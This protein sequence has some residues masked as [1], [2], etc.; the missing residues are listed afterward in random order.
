[1]I[2]HLVGADRVH[3]DCLDVVDRGAEADGLDDGRRAGLELPRQVVRG[4][5]VEADVADHLAAAEERR[6]RVE[7]L[8]AGPQRADPGRAEHLVRREGDEV[9]VPRLHVGRDVRHELARVDEDERAVR[10]RGV[11][12]RTDV[13]D[14]AEH[15]RHRADGEERGAVEQRVEVREVEA[16]VGGE[17]DPAQL[18]AAFGGE[19]LPRNDVGVVLHV[20]EH[21]RVAGL[22]VGRAPTC[23][24]RG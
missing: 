20:R 5:A 23:T 16:E 14:R 12:E 9:G 15:V 22:Q 19:H 11:G 24:R 2:S 10:V 8:V 3:A 7:Q 17:R 21:D 18:D 1:M 6:H 13:V 4:E